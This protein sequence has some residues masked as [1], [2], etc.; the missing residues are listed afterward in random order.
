MS[1]DGSTTTGAER[2]A[3]ADLT[4]TRSGANEQ[5]VREVDASDEEDETDGDREGEDRW[6]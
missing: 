1:R 2:G 3:H 6:T 4:L 5:E